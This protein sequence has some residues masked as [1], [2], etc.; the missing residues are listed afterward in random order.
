METSKKDV[1]RGA[2][3]VSDEVTTNRGLFFFIF[4]A[5][6]HHDPGGCYN[7]LP[8]EILARDRAVNSVSPLRS[9]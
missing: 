2:H 1:E 3:R 5:L 6:H 8:L 4:S 9:S 7:Q